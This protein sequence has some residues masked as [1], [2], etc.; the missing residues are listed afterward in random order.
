MSAYSG[1]KIDS[2]LVASNIKSGVDIF[3]VV[4]NYAPTITGIAPNIFV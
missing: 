2:N 3:G 1:N 4:G